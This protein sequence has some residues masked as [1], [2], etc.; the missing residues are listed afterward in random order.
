MN[1]YNKKDSEIKI[2]I[3]KKDK[4]ILVSKAKSGN[5]TLTDLILERCLKN[6]NDTLPV[7]SVVS[8]LN[9]YN[10]ILQMLLKKLF[11]KIYQK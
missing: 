6:D 7:S 11:E 4:D 5:M 9:S 10:K 3:C 8:V 2:R 1:T